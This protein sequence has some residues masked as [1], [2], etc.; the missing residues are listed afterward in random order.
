VKSKIDINEHLGRRLRCRRR[1]L[2]LTQQALASSGGLQF[3][4]IQKYECGAN[5]MSAQRLW[6]LAACLET[7]VGYFYEGLSEG[8]PGSG[9]SD[10]AETA[11]LLR[12]LTSLS[13]PSRRE[14]LVTMQAMRDDRELVGLQ[15][16]RQV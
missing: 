3:Q 15:A 4:Q 9:P 5:A 8:P 13:P 11:E 16:L 14:L 12:V 6:L 10:A 1:L 2:G 7:P